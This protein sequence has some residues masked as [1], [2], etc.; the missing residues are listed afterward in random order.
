MQSH[1]SQGAASAQREAEQ[2]IAD[3]AQ[4]HRDVHM[5]DSELE[6]QRQQQL[7]AMKEKEFEVDAQMRLLRAKKADAASQPKPVAAGVEA[8]YTLMVLANDYVA[9]NQKV[10]VDANTRPAPPAAVARP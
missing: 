3:V 8:K 1:A 6:M 4:R 10:V 7:L 2:K 9:A 5:K